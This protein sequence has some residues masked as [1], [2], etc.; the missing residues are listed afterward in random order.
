MPELL[1]SHDFVTS[2]GYSLITLH[3]Q[4]C[5]AGT[6]AG[7]AITA[8]QTSVAASTEYCLYVS[9][10][11]DIIPVTIKVAIWDG[12][13]EGRGEHL[14][15]ECPSGDLMLGSPTGEIFRVELPRGPGDYTVMVTHEGRAEADAQRCQLLAQL[16]EIDDL[17]DAA[18]E[19]IGVERYTIALWQSR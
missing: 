19:H 2:P 6:N 12:P 8:A 7:E 17:S 9:C 1:A 15:L 3:D 10:A 4:D 11:Q 18:E 5:D 16:D 14:R 13:P